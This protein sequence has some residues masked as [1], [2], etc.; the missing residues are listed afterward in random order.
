[1]DFLSSDTKHYID[2]VCKLATNHDMKMEI[3]FLHRMY[4]KKKEEIRQ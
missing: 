3:D 4:N 1:M 2:N